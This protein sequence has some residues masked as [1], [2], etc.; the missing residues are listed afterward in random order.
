MIFKKTQAEKR[1][2]FY[3]LYHSSEI[4]LGSIMEK[5]WGIGVE[6]NVSPKRAF[7]LAN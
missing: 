1:G 5:I 2:T 3:F 6:K 7:P 4:L